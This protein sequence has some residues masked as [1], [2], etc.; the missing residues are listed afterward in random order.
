MSLRSI[1]QDP[2]E[3]HLQDAIPPIWAA[4]AGQPLTF[5]WSRGRRQWPEGFWFDWAISPSSYPD[6]QAREGICSFGKLKFKLGA[7][8]SGLSEAPLVT[9]GIC[10]P[11]LAPL[12]RPPDFTPKFVGTQPERFTEPFSNGLRIAVRSAR[13]SEG[14]AGDAY[15]RHSHHSSCT[16]CHIL[17]TCN[18][19]SRFA[20]VP[21]PF[22]PNLVSSGGTEIRLS[23][24]DWRA[25]R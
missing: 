12:P 11:N 18:S 2:K 9:D 7:N 23:A 15:L 6:C 17:V 21:C 13:E 1:L 8:F 24:V 5:S 19:F 16:H 22:R 3:E 14:Q 20:P 25:S 4:G 10:Q